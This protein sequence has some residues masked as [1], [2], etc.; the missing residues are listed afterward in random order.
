MGW[1]AFPASLRQAVFRFMCGPPSS[2]QRATASR[3]KPEEETVSCILNHS[4]LERPAAGYRCAGHA[5][6]SA[7]DVRPP[8]FACL[9]NHRTLFNQGHPFFVQVS[10][11]DKQ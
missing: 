8:C 11:G 10:G 7:A 6:A 3:Q 9:T 5:R 4:S 2:L 1:R